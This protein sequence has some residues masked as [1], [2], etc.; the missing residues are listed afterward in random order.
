MLGLNTTFSLS[1]LKIEIE[2]E[3]YK[4]RL[5]YWKESIQFSSYQLFA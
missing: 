1:K 2:I 3:S 4:T 5:K